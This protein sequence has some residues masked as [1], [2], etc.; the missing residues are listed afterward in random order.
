MARRSAAHSCSRSRSA[1]MP[2]PLAPTSSIGRRRSA[3]PARG[4]RSSRR[5]GATPRRRVQSFAAHGVKTVYLETGR[6]NSTGA[7]AE[8]RRDGSVHRRGALGRSG[9]RRVVLPDVPA[10]RPRRCAPAR[11][12]PLPEP[13][14][15]DVRR[16]RHRHRGHDGQDHHAPEHPAALA[17][18]AGARRGAG[19][20]D[21]RDHV[22]AGR[23]RPE[24]Q[25]VA[26]LPV[27]GRREAL[28]RDASDGVLALRHARPRRRRLVHGREPPCAAAPHR[29]TRTSSCTS[30]GSLPPSEAEVSQFAH[31][32]VL[33][34]RGRV[35]P[36]SGAGRDSSAEWP[37][38]N[39]AAATLPTA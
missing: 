35:Q 37:I 27:V 14:G 32:A 8:A 19:D 18:A 23:A 24:H 3:D 5:S 2:A 4:S 31:Q 39:A 36:V 13:V 15:R 25:G 38:L 26:A 1:R 28:G 21:R 34:R 16:P 22:P 33:G 20:A 9:H 10:A 30:S 7:I 12:G 11:D 6:S 29:A 17:D